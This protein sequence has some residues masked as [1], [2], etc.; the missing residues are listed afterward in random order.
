[1]DAKY[2]TVKDKRHLTIACCDIYRMRG[3]K[4]SEWRVYADMLP[5]YQTDLE[6][7]MSSIKQSQDF[8]V[9]PSD[10]PDREAVYL[11]GDMYT[12]LATGEETRGQFVLFDFFV[13][14]E[15]GP[16]LHL[17]YLEDE[18]LYVLEGEVEFQ[19]GDQILVG[20]TGTFVYLPKL[21][22]HRFK[23]IG[24]TSATLLSLLNPSG[25]EDL[26]REAGYPVTNRSVP[27]PPT[28]PESIKRL[29]EAGN[30]ASRG[31]IVLPGEPLPPTE[32]LQNFLVV[33]PDA[34]GRESVSIGGGLYTYLATYE[35][36]DGHYTIFRA[37]L[38]PQAKSGPLPIPNQDQALYV[39]E[40][41]LSLQLENRTMLATR[42]TFVY[43]P[44]GKSFTFQNLGKTQAKALLI[45]FKDMPSTVST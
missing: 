20:T 18:W 28:T 22:P 9:V 16:P 26:F 12:F 21:R 13:P 17:H 43:I 40:G 37:S 35:E 4:V 7:V 27:P 38:P 14:P 2:T 44:N 10:A 19:M 23:N 42:K 6:K 45:A 30:R 11:S 25:I 36:T 33:P 34:P 15:G 5:L 3:N 32:G 41:E 1:M 29:V 24:K 31:T 39:L 8:L